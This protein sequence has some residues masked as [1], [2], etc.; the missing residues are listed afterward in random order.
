M[1]DL[2]HD[3]L[4]SVLRDWQERRWGAILPQGSRNS[5]LF[6]SLLPALS[7][8]YQPRRNSHSILHFIRK[9]SNI[10]ETVRQPF[11]TDLLFSRLSLLQDPDIKPFDHVG[12]NPTQKR[13]CHGNHCSQDDRFRPTWNA[14]PPLQESCYAFHE[15]P[16]RRFALSLRPRMIRVKRLFFSA[17][18]LSQRTQVSMA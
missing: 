7:A 15:V 18:I 4:A 3:E 12:N 1:N 2:I 6:V 10:E 11:T 16:S 9:N 17:P 5:V 14:G 8:P 13:R